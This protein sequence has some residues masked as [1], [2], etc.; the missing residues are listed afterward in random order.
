MYKVQ[1]I[2]GGISKP[3]RQ[4]EK[5]TPV[6][7]EISQTA[8]SHLDRMAECKTKSV[9]THNF[10]IAFV[11]GKGITALPHGNNK[12]TPNQGRSATRRKKKKKK[13]AALVIMPSNTQWFPP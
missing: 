1:P 12:K 6:P 13:V 10:L 7:Y 4:K 2:S 8:R 3:D 11:I 5:T 9:Q